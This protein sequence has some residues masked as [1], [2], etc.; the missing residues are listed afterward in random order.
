LSPRFLEH[1]WQVLQDSAPSYPTSEVVSRWR[2]LPAPANGGGEGAAEARAG[3][4]EVQR[5]LIDWPRWL[6]GAGGAAEGGQGDERALVLT[7]ASVK[8][9]PTHRFRFFVRSREKAARVYLSAV[10]MNP[11]ASGQPAI[12]WRNGVVRFRSRERGGGAQQSL[13]TAL[14]AEDR[15]RIGAAA[16]AEE[17]MLRAGDS[18]Y[19]DIPVPEGAGGL[20]LEIDAEM[21]AADAAGAVIRCTVSNHAELAKGRPVSALLGYPDS[22]AFRAWKTGVLEFAARMPQISQGEPTPADRDPIPPPF[23]DEYNQPERD[24]FHTQLKYYRDDRFLVEKMLDDA[25]RAQL[26]HAWADLLSSFEYHDLFLRFVAEKFK[27]DLNDKGISALTAAEIAALPLEPR[28]YVQALR[29]EYDAMTAAQKAAQPGHIEDCLRFASEAWRRPLTAIEKDRLRSFYVKASEGAKLEHPK[30]IRALLARILVAPAFLYRLEQPPG[31]TGV[32]AL[33]G[34]EMANR[35]SFFLW[36]SAPD[37]ELRRAAAAGELTQPQALARQVKRMLADTKARRLAVEF[38]GQWLG[39][40]RFDEHRGVDPGRFPEFT[41][42]VKSAMYDEAISFFEHI[43]RKDRPVRDI[44]FA[45]YTFLTPSLAKHYGVSK[46]IESHGK[47][48]LVEDADAFHRGGLLR[49]GAVLTATSAPLRTSPVKRGDWVLRRVLGTPTPPPPPDAGSIPADD[50]LFGGLSLQERLA[51]H[52]RNP[53]CASCH[54][55]IDPLGFP[56]ES[57]DPVGR[58]RK[59]YPDGKPVHDSG[60]LA[61]GAKISGVDGLLEYLKEQER[62]V[63]K[64][65]SSKLLGYAL[66]RTVQAS[67]LPLIERMTK[68]GGDTS[69]SNVVLEIVNSRQFRYRRQLED[70]SSGAAVALQPRKKGGA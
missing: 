30:A 24:R 31:L 3:C 61:T 41:P 13:F 25:T 36:S 69:F 28:K 19:L 34:W 39:F 65:F 67:D 5:F 59:A 40:Y 68:A 63:W 37:A 62:Q 64:T 54:T 23:N 17:F 33:S 7:D 58:F 38:F 44:L 35:L 22:D 45:D 56:L 50:K 2:N 48:E 52:Q 53:S 49:L 14:S 26:E 11:A 4:D 55:R 20:G 46:K 21:D 42:E 29:A 70:G 9:A 27:L 43:V 66:G 6:L 51:V 16:G 8:A 32:R 12:R 18:I 10:S 1:I 15:K 60:A 47:P 57:Y